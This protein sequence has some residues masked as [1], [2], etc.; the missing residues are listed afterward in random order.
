[1]GKN[2]SQAEFNEIILEKEI[3]VKITNSNYRY[4]EEAGF[5]VK[6]ENGKVD[7]NKEIILNPYILSISSRYEV[8]PICQKCGE[9]QKKR[10]IQKVWTVL[11]ANDGQY[12]C[13]DCYKKL[14]S[15]EKKNKN[16][17]ETKFYIEN[18]TEYLYIDH[19]YKYYSKRNRLF[20]KLKCPKHGIFEQ[21]STNI[22][23]NILCR[24]CGNDS[25]AYKRSTHYPEKVEILKNIYSNEEA[26]IYAKLFKNLQ[27][28]QI[29]RC[30]HC[31]G[32]WKTSLR[33]IKYSNI[34]GCKNCFSDRYS[35]ENA[36]N[37]RG[38]I[39]EITLYLR[40]SIKYWIIESRKI[41]NNTCILTGYHSKQEN[42][43][44]HHVFCDFNSLLHE[45]FRITGLRKK[46]HLCDY[47]KEELDF[48]KD[49][50]IILHYKSGYGVCLSEKVHYD[51]HKEKGF[52]NT[53]LNDFIEYVSENYPHKKDEVIF[54]LNKI[55]P[56]FKIGGDL[57]IEGKKIS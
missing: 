38:G 16:I 52:N 36:S 40:N 43:D 31:S 46:E 54:I 2:I 13:Y 20:F 26:E 6:K 11:N 24:K 39:Q 3:I 19:Y 21:E 44:V 27:E 23:K 30:P 9:I 15:L 10:T 37:W 42:L 7:I 41:F 57:E 29:I 18:N 51:F 12:L 28:Y 53:T 25:R 32:E 17:E 47:S 34:K 4:L 33:I 55:K 48:L 49:I 5:N 50:I 56:S 1:M 14:K 22:K 35:G 45:T 8:T